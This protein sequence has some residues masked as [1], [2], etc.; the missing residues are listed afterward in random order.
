MKSS[1]LRGA[2]LAWGAILASGTVYSQAPYFAGPNPHGYS[3]PYS[4]P[5]SMPA[6]PYYSLPPTQLPNPAQTFAQPVTAPVNLAGQI[7]YAAYSRGNGM[8]GPTNLVSEVP[9]S[10]LAMPATPVLGPPNQGQAAPPAG[11]ENIG[12]GNPIMGP[13]GMQSGGQIQAPQPGQ[14]PNYG[15]QYPGQNYYYG[16]GQSPNGVPY[17]S[18]TGTNGIEYGAAPG[19]GGG[20]G[21]GGGG[22]GYGAGVGAGSL[23]AGYGGYSGMGGYTEGGYGYGGGYDGSCG[24]AAPRQPRWYAG[25]YGLWLTR[26]NYENYAFSYDT[27][28]E[29]VQLTNARDANANWDGGFAVAV[30]HY[31]NCGSNA[32][33]FVYWG[34][35][36]DDVSVYT[37]ESQVNGQL[38]GIHNWNSLDYDGQIANVWVDDAN[39]HA[40]W[41][42]TEVHNFELNV[43]RIG[44]G[45]CGPWQYSLVGGSRIFIYEDT[46]T[47]GSETTDRFF[48]G[49]DSEIYYRV[50][51]RNKLYGFQLGGV[52][53]YCAT[54]RLVFNGGTKF[55]V[56]VN[57]ISHQSLI[58]GG[59]GLAIINNGPNGGQQWLVENSKDDI[60]FLGE[61]FLGASYCLTPR[62]SLSGGY[63]AIAVTGVAQPTDQIYPDLRGINDAYSIESNSS[64]ILHGA[65]LG[66]QFCW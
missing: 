32:L 64:M 42:Q 17:G 8:T 7:N 54:Q 41:R 65:Y 33:E 23:G 31:F 40:L 29:A 56:F 48:D 9:M 22:M 61:V 27:T 45:G 18:G 39:V 46:L 47:F 4:Q 62:W 38:N 55:G 16:Y 57:K 25:A 59:G 26:D 14:S 21:A 24:Y 34:W 30:G 3:Q 5:Y 13:G 12:P 44:G 36:P 50:N 20:Y 19:Y 58:G 63:R 10:V 60:S 2:A 6:Q 43:L 28:N 51:T 52:G 1:R 37:Y 49:D 15:Q 35:Y 66:A 53:S 11:A